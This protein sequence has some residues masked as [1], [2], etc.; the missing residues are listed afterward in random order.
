[1]IKYYLKTVPFAFDVIVENY[2]NA[3]II[4]G[5]KKK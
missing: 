3:C 2:C 1:M 4:L 5:A